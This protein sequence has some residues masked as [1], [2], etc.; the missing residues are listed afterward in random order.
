VSRETLFAEHLKF[1]TAIT[2]APARALPNSPEPL[3][4]L[5]VGFL[6]PDLREHSVAYF[7]EPLLAHL[8]PTQFEI[9]LYHDH[10]RIDAMSARLRT[11][12]TVWRH[13][14]GFSDDAVEAAIR[15]DTPDVLVDLAGHTGI[16]RLPL[17]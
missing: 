1:G 6:S 4:R 5:R 7:L 9:F 2:E 15:A 12:T 10:P 17:F 11:V 3:R 8:D 13:F 14:A 16:N